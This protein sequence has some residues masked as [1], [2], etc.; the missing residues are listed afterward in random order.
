MPSFDPDDGVV[1]MAPERDEPGYWVG[2]PAVLHEPENGRFLLT[3]RQRRPR[4][5]EAERGWRCAVATSVDGVRFTDVWSVHKDELGTPS[6]E[7]FSLLPTGDGRYRLYMS[8]VDP[9]DNRWRI[10][11]LTADAPDRFDVANAEPVLTAESTG[12]EG[13][14]D[15]YT[16]RVGPVT[17]LFA[18]YAEARA[19]LPPEAHGSAD[20][21]NVGATTHPTG[22]ATSLDVRRFDWHGAVLRTGDG[23]D[24][25]QARLN[26]MVAI[27]G[28]YLGFY[29]GSAGHA[30][31]Y[32]ER[33]GVA[34]SHDLRHWSS[35]SPDG[36]WLTSRH[37]TG[38]VR[39]VDALL[40]DGR[41]WLY[42]ER[43]RD[44]GAH[45]LRLA[46]APT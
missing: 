11:V 9:T 18:S 6:M 13:V 14:K 30:E 33:C 17:Y 35:L 2:C 38:S 25:Y 45:E 42:Y 22:M 44:D 24:G 12:T 28:G 29:D 20:I 27:H 46:T 4:G 8:Y 1:V 41:W 19:D 10:D 23:W 36:P 34:V 40:V 7:R 43:S 15:P 31:N 37:G 5:A 3:Y 26:S 21:Y 39:Y 16:M 32:E